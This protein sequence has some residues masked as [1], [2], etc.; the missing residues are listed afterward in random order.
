MANELAKQPQPT[1]NELTPNVAA[2][3]AYLL[4]FVTGVIFLLI[5][6]DKFVRFH[7]LQSIFLAVTFIVIDSILGFTIILA[8]FIPLLGLLQLGASIAM[9]VKAY[10]GEK[11][12]LP[13]IGDLA[14][15]H[16]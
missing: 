13:V 3:L 15:K 7:A 4:S 2:T 1:P 6:K 14:E 11:Y 10:Q 8:I 9:M 5:S 12:K 16:A